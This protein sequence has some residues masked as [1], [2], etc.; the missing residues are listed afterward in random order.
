MFNERAAIMVKRGGCP[1]VQ[2]SL[3]IQKIGGKLAILADNLEE[4]EEG[5]IMVDYKS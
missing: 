3:N 1:F 4:D 5:I 2:K